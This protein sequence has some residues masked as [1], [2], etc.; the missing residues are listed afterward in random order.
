[1]ECKAEA[2]AKLE[3]D[4]NCPRF[5]SLSILSSFGLVINLVLVEKIS[6]TKP[7]TYTFAFIY[8]FSYAIVMT[9]DYDVRQDRAR[10][11]YNEYRYFGNQYRDTVRSRFYN[12]WINAHQSAPKSELP[13][14]AGLLLYTVWMAW[15]LSFAAYYGFAKFG[16][17]WIPGYVRIGAAAYQ[18]CFICQLLASFFV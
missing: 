12:D 9:H 11:S 13:Y 3:R 16:A 5:Y 18:I 1:L 17:A 2:Y 14:L 10:C 15:P 8:R 4:S 7:V 6:L